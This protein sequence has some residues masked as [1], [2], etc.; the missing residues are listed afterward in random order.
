MFPRLVHIGSFYLPTYGLMLAVAYLTAIW[1][2]RR[3]AIAEGLPEQKILD[4]SLYILASAILGAKILLVI[5]EWR[6]YTSQPRDL[7]EV[8]RSG[9]VFYGGF[10]CATVVAI[11]YMRRHRLP[12]WKIADMGA[13][14]IALGE[15]I[16]RWGCF[17]AGCCYGKEWHGPWAVT[18]RDPFAHDNVGTPL[19][20]PLHPTQIY[21]SINALVIFLVLQ[22]AY[23]RKTFDGEVFWLYVLLYSITR[24][25]I[26]V[27]RGDLVRGFVIPGVLSTSQFIGVLA[28]LASL[29]M[30]FYLSRRERQAIQ[31]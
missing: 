11:W 16:G 23:R 17:A 2:L 8:L 22:W 5:V 15:A 10:I 1:L 13:P 24:G 14:S 19:N 26:E 28:A 31:D 7:V 27:W 20:T 4:L 12:S 18:F 25:I 21:L 30:L 29:G 3:K 9:G 6:H